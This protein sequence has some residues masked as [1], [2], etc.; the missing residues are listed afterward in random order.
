MDLLPGPHRGGLF[1]S[2]GRIE[3]GHKRSLS[4]ATQC[5]GG[6]PGHARPRGRFLVPLRMRLVSSDGLAAFLSR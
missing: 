1:L 2:L 6:F 4:N 3:I 5:R